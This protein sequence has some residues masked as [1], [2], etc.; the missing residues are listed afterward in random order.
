MTQ[1]AILLLHRADGSTPGAPAIAASVG[2]GDPFAAQREIVWA[3]PAAMAAGR[4][5][6]SGT[7]TSAAYPH[8]ETLVVVAGRLR[9]SPGGAP[10]LDL[11]P[12]GAAVIA[13]GTSLTLEAA[14]GTRWV[15]STAAGES[16]VQPGVTELHAD[17]PLAPSAGPA[18]ELLVG[19]APQCRSFNAVID[20]ATGVRV[21]TWD[22]TPGHRRARPHPVNE[23]M[24]IIEGSVELAE[25]GGA[26]TRLQAGDSVFAVKGT[27]YAWDN[28]VHITKFYLVQDV[29][30]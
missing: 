7:L 22:S 24:H 8:G 17:A 11:G 19:P 12:G 14:P 13:A 3:G 5:A 6:F 25:P 18:P 23:L 9:L 30:P 1:P 10:A 27:S 15:F 20:K 16:A 2:A 26:V 29:A 28:P 21:G 4:V